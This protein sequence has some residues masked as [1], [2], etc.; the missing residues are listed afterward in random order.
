MRTLIIIFVILILSLF[1]CC[2][3]AK[4][5]YIKPSSYKQFEIYA[6]PY[7]LKL[8]VVITEDTIKALKFLHNNT[9]SGFK[10]SDFRGSAAIT[11]FGKG[12]PT[13]W[14]PHLSRSTEDIATVGH[15]LF[16]AT[17][18]IMDRV[19]IPLS[20]DSEEAFA[21]EFDYLLI[22]IYKHIK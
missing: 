19:R 20:D 1:T 14:F 17:K 21:Y 10:I 7:G 13:I 12:T 15:E 22:Q 9:D 4:E 2:V 8:N 5:L 18:A 11:F 6:N 16:H 3:P